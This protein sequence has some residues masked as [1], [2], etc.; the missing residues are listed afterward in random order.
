[1]IYEGADIYKILES[2]AWKQRCRTLLQTYFFRAGQFS[3]V[4]TFPDARLT[5]RGKPWENTINTLID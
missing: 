2:E 1:M 4:I 5:T 3:G